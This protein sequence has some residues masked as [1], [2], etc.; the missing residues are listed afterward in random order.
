MTLSRARGVLNCERCSLHRIR[1]GTA[2]TSRNSARSCAKQRHAPQ[3]PA[4]ALQAEAP[5]RRSFGG[6]HRRCAQTKASPHRNWIAPSGLN[7]SVRCLQQR[8]S[9]D[10]QFL[11]TL[12]SDAIAPNG[13]IP[14]PKVRT[15]ATPHYMR[16]NSEPLVCTTGQICTGSLPMRRIDCA[17]LR[18]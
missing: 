11:T 10:L 13:T 16:A 18:A 14:Y 15:P 12:P 6:V 7:C 1:F 5:V 3:P 8:A 9:R 2:P 17:R 4:A